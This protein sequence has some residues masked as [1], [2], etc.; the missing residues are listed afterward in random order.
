VMGGYIDIQK[1]ET[2]NH[3]SQ[4]ETRFCLPGTFVWPGT[5]LIWPVFIRVW[6]GPA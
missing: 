1:T 4:A 6:A 2:T 3:G 5:S